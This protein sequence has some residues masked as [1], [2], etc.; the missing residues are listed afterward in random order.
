M[1][2][3]WKKPGLNEL[4]PDEVARIFGELP[5]MDAVRLTG[6]EPFVRRDLPELARLAQMKL[7][8]LLLHITT[9][10]FLTERIV[11]LCEDGRRR[12][13]LELLIS[14]DGVG[15]KHNQI[16]GHSGAW[17]S[18]LETLQALAP[19]QQKLRLRLAVNQTV[20][21]AEGIDHYRMLRSLAQRL[22]V[23]HQMVMA[24]EA[25]ATYSLESEVDVAPKEIGQFATF[26]NFT[27]EQMG[28]LLDEAESD[29]RRLP[30]PARL[31][32]RYYYRGLRQRLLRQPVVANPQ[33]VALN[34][35]LRIFPN[36]DVP[37]C[38]FNSRVVGNLRRQSFHEVWNAAR[39]SEQ[40]QWVR[41]CPGCWAECE[42]LPSAIYSGDLLLQSLRPS[43]SAAAAL[44]AAKQP[45]GPN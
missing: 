23:R 20:V 3:S 2:D 41:R 8:P 33:C 12:V 19:R 28:E 7:R 6:G 27:D 36:G 11:E 1:C 15:E 45:C 26:G 13:P 4:T 14:V 38:Q 31:A 25:S 44:P 43:R 16:R 39:T 21:D 17:R 34:S 18:C 32:K 40:R 35:H 22:G 24:Y 5:R 29:L 9:N 10:G 42:A 30:A 37:T